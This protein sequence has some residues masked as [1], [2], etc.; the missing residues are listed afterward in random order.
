MHSNEWKEKVVQLIH[1]WLSLRKTMYFIIIKDIFLHEP[2]KKIMIKYQC[3]NKRIGDTITIEN[4]MSSPLKH[5]THP[6]QIFQIGMKLEK[7][8]NNLTKHNVQDLEDKKELLVRFKRVFH[9][10]ANS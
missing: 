1:S 5:A 7:L 10:E 9:Q 2:T 8:L 3:L 6:D 4:F